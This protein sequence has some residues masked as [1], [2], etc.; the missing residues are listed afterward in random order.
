LQTG[1]RFRDKN[2]TMTLRKWKVSYDSSGLVISTGVN[3]N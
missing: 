3:R 2:A 1:L